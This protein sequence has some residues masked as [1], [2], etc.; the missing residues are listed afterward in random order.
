MRIDPCLVWQPS[1]LD[2]YEAADRAITRIHL[3]GASWV[4]HSPAWWPGADALFDRLVAGLDW[5]ED[6]RTM[7]ERVVTVPRLTAA[8]PADAAVRP[9]VDPICDVLSRRYGVTLDRVWC[10]L[11][12]G[13]ADSVAWHGDRIRY[14]C[15]NPLVAIV[16]LGERRRFL[17]KPRSG[18]ISRRWD[19]GHGDLLVMGGSCQHDHLHCVP[20]VARAGPRLSVT[21]RH[22]DA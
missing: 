19:L 16:S 22:A 21:F 15:K 17:L 13:G 10:N 7:Y 4:D 6:D 18:G 20:K 8:V 14:T 1:L 11:Y 5:R 12:R 2:G 9:D 3:D